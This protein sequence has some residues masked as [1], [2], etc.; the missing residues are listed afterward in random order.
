MTDGTVGLASEIRLSRQSIARQ[1]GVPK[2]QRIN[3]IV[4]SFLLHE[5]VFVESADD[6]IMIS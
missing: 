6:T 1:Q 3:T 5:F 2:G 4:S